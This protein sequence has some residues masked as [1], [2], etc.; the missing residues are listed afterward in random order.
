MKA[1]TRVAKSKK[2]IFGISY[3]NFTAHFN[4]LKLGYSEFKAR[5]NIIH[6]T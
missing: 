1:P 3:Y 4:F 5:S 2:G 6:L